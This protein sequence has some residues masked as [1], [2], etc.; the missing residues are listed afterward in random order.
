M[1]KLSRLILFLL[2]FQMEVRVRAS[3]D[4]LQ[5]PEACLKSQ[6]SCAIHVLGTGFHLQKKS[7]VLHATE[8]STLMRLSQKNWKLIKGTLWVEKANSVE[9]E[10]AYASVKSAGGQYWLLQKN[11]QVIIRNINAELEVTLRDG[12]KLEVPE[13]FEFWVSGINSKGLSEYGMIHPISLKEHLVLWNSLYVGGKANF[14]KEAQSLKE[15]WGGLTEK[16]SDLYQ[17]IIKR[18]MASIAEQDRLLE[19][20]KHQEAVY[21]QNLKKIYFQRTFER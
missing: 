2:A 18:K 4:L 7:L 1:K 19:E 14:L 6:Q 20:K 21:R 13:G 9:V 17:I 15:D 10:T 11:D 3:G 16:S 12:K 8:G 5:E